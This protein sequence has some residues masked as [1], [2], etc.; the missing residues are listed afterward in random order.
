MAKISN[1]YCAETIASCK[2][3]HSHCFSF[4]EIV[5]KDSPGKSFGF[6]PRILDMKY[7]DLDM[8]ETDAKGDNDNT[9]DLAVGVSEYDDCLCVNSSNSL[10]LVELKLNCGKFNLKER[11]LLSKDKHSREMCKEEIKCSDAS[12]F[13][14]P[15]NLVR[16]A[17][18]F[19]ERW[20]RGSGSS[21][22]N[23][24]EFL[25]AKD[26]NVYIH[27]SED[28]PY[29]HK[30]NFDDIDYKIDVFVSKGQIGACADYI[31]TYVKELAEYYW[32]RRN[33]NELSFI[34]GRLTTKME[35][36]YLQ[37]FAD[38]VE[39]AYLKLCADSVLSLGRQ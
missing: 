12:V 2:F 38:Q 25:S 4:G 5:G 37:S 39:M 6:A 24:W 21:R 8:I 30:T 13:L 3:Q 34:I 35:S 36:I 11:D 22:L 9:M 28:Y 7:L 19:L 20:R 18:N 33:V 10:L 32:K 27:F 31:D 29:R 14:F 26:F 16:Q 23:K 1:V 17:R 15:E